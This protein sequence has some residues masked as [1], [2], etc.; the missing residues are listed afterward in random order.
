MTNGFSEGEGVCIVCLS[1]DEWL[2]AALGCVDLLPDQSVMELSRAI[3]NYFRQEEDSQEYM[4]VDN[5]SPEEGKCPRTI[6]LGIYIYIYIFSIQQL[7][8]RH[9]PF[10]AC[11][12]SVGIK[13]DKSYIE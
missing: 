7:F 4:V 9:I 12:H 6:H 1:E 10:F 11:F 2:C 3:P 13:N 5:I 8:K